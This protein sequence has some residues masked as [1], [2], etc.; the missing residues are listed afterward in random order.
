MFRGTGFV[1]VGKIKSLH[2]QATSCQGRW[3]NRGHCQAVRRFSSPRAATLS[4]NQPPSRGRRR[5]ADR[6][7]RRR[8]AC[9]KALAAGAWP[10]PSSG[11]MNRCSLQSKGSDCRTV[12]VVLVMGQGSSGPYAAEAMLPISSAARKGQGLL[13]SASR[14]E[15]RALSSSSEGRADIVHFKYSCRSVYAHPPARLFYDIVTYFL[16]PP[17]RTRPVLGAGSAP[18]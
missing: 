7:P 12:P 6:G 15:C 13:P 1:D 10:Y 2:L 3:P 16:T 18:A 4:N 9:A 8:A 14:W 17:L 11:R 5:E